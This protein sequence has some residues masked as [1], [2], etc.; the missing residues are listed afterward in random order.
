M[1][2]AFQTGR[3]HFMNCFRKSSNSCLKCF[4][5]GTY[6]NI[7]RKML[8]IQTPSRCLQSM[9]CQIF[10]TVTSFRWIP[11]HLSTYSYALKASGCME[12]YMIRVAA[13]PLSREVCDAI[14]GCQ[15]L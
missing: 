13:V 10:E 15:L 9:S 12:G 6:F 8:T 11:H 5:P 7:I 4:N 2:S 1:I 3:V 14:D